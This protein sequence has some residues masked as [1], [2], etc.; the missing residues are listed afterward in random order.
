M[1]TNRLWHVC[2]I[3]KRTSN[4][5]ADENEAKSID[6]LQDCTLLEKLHNN[7]HITGVHWTH[8]GKP[9]LSENSSIYKGGDASHPALTILYASNEDSGKYV[10]TVTFANEKITEIKEYRVDLAVSGE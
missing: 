5:F 4:I 7:R 3:I 2:A 1:L 8:N 6:L 10:C 9:V